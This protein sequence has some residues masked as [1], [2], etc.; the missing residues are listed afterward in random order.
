MLQW[1]ERGK[2]KKAMQDQCVLRVYLLE[3][4]KRAV[5]GFH[6]ALLDSNEAFVSL[7]MKSEESD[8]ESIYTFEEIIF[9]FIFRTT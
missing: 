8:E 9:G 1:R 4:I 6:R 3:D 5:C 2:E 7:E